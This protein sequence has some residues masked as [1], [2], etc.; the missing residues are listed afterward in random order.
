MLVTVDSPNSSVLRAKTVPVVGGDE[1]I[2]IILALE[3]EL[4]LIGHGVGLAAPQIGISKSIA[5]IRYGGISL[6]LINPSV[7]GGGNEFKSEMEGCL[8]FPGRC[9]DVPRFGTIRI[10]NHLLWPAAVGSVALSDD[11]NRKPIDRLNYPKGMNLVPAEQV[12]VVENPVEDCGGI[13]CVAVQHELE[14]L[15]GVTL[16]TKQ[17]A[18][19]HY[20]L[21]TGDKKVGRN[22][23]CPCGS[24]KK[25]K[26]CCLTGK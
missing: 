14:H 5:I 25:Y 21:A 3:A 22:D 17:G 4:E 19:E 6:N 18:K 13:I 20:E 8:S 7:I 9:W 2:Q 11:V 1:A 24:G 10:Q 12:Y 16:D 26:K 23:P 15:L